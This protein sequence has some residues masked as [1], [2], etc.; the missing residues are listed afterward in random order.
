MAKQAAE[1]IGERY[2]MDVADVRDNRY[3][4]GRTN[5]VAVYTLLD[6]YVCAPRKGQKPPA[7][8]RWKPDGASHGGRTIYFA[9]SV[10]E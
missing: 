7:G 9:T 4:P 10:E 3:Q 5:G 8:W 1:H 6:G 2:G